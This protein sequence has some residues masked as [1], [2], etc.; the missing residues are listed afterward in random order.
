MPKMQ[1]LGPCPFLVVSWEEEVLNLHLEIC[2]R[3]PSTVRHALIEANLCVTARTRP[4]QTREN[5]HCLF[6]IRGGGVGGG[7]PDLGF[8]PPFM[9]LLW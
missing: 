1:E 7:N 5:C 9:K 4:F 6:S 2:P 3:G 8:R